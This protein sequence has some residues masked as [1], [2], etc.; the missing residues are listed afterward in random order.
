[1]STKFLSPGWRMPRNANQSKFSNY[2]MNF[3]GSS[4]ID[5]GD[6]NAFS[7]GN[8][9]TDSPF[10]I[11][12]WVNATNFSPNGIRIIT[13][14]SDSWGGREYQFYIDSSGKL[15]LLIYDDSEQAYRLRKYDTSLNTGQWYHV[16]ATYNGLGGS[17]AENGIKLFLNGTYLLSTVTTSYGNYT[18]MEN[19]TTPAYIGTMHTYYSNGKINEASIF[20]YELSSS[21]V[22]TLWGGGTSVSNPMALPSP[23]IAY[24]PLGE[25]AGGFVGGSGTWLTEN[26]AIGD[27]VFD[28]DADIGGDFIDLGSSEVLFN[29]TSGFS[30]STW[31]KLENYSVVSYPAFCRL[32][33]DQAT[34]FIIGLSDI[35]GYQGVY[36]G[37]NSNFLT[38]RTQGD[39]SSDFI[40]VW[41][42]VV[43]TFDGVN[44]TTLSSYKIYVDGQPITLTTA[45]TFGTTLNDNKLG[46][47]NGTGTPFNGLLSNSQIFDSALSSTDVETLYNYGSP[48]RTLANIP[49]SSNLK[50]WYKLDASEV[51]NNTTTE[52]S[53]DNNQN[54]SAYAS[55]LDFDSAD[56]DYIEIPKDSTL[57]FVNTDFSIS[58]WLNPEVS[59]NGLVM[60]NYYGSS[61]WGLYYQSG[62]IRFYDSLVWTTVTTINTNEWTHILIVGDY[63]GSNLLCYKNGVEVYNSSHTFS[64]TDS[65]TSVFIGSERG[66]GFFFN[67]SISNASIWNSAL[68]STQVTELYNNGTPSNLSNHSAT[69]NLVSWW[70]LNNTTTG[71]EDAKGSNNGTNYGATK[72]PGFVNTLA[73]E[74]S[75]MTQANL[76]Q[77]D[78]QTVA[79]YSKY[80]MNFDSAS[81]DYIDC[82]D[83]DDFSFGDS[84][85]DSPFSISAWVNIETA[86]NGGIVSKFLTSTATKEWMFELKADRKLRFFLS[87]SN[88]QVTHASSST[89]LSLN[90]WYHVVAIYDGR[91]GHDANLGMN[92]YINNFSESLVYAT[93]NYSAM[94]NTNQPVEIGRRSGSNYLNGKISNVSIW[95]SALTSAQVT[96]LYNQGLPSNLNSHSAY[97]NLVSWWQ[98]G[99][100]SSFDG[101]D[102]ICADEKGTNNGTSVSM[103]VGALVNGVGTTANGVSSGMSEGNLVG[104]A[105]YSTAN[106]LSTNMIVTSRVSGSGNTP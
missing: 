26:N 49:Q 13:K 103:P 106:A 43:V 75:G 87:A 9:T 68:T 21:Q 12:A 27:Y 17:N 80:A 91:G 39:I 95:N 15:I 72:Y 84:T 42:H 23:P 81:S 74:S 37:S 98:L 93:Q 19:T 45:G 96:E 53:I 66:A 83:S 61:G 6:D 77:S 94:Q 35:S 101:N 65:N 31:C 90:T 5:L 62:S 47:G 102:W 20:D 89:A 30:F 4:Y 54:P 41:K 70:K 22:T 86:T 56:S 76:V 16:A 59:H 28:F 11:S 50:A 32:K 85:N 100:N 48:I 78:L 29:S 34:G 46:Y 64:I 99:E 71:I 79:P 55:S 33:T 67:G 38:A 92:I 14:C 104:D 60:M 18:A 97:S 24:Y 1:M 52:W 58:I 36:I 10:S 25:S 7:F 2:S 51:Y 63:T 40:G 57:S 3:N 73:G 88:G 82:G 8:D 44:R 69:S 105:P